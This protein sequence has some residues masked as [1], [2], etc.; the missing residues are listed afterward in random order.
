MDEADENFNSWTYWN[1]DIWDNE[2]NI[3]PD[4]AIVF[5]RPYPMAISGKPEKVKMFNR[6]LK[7]ILAGVY[8]FS[9]CTYKNL[10]MY[11]SFTKHQC[12]ILLR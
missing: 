1:R 7:V 6:L 4:T 12:F 10:Y 11:V 9:F 5:A 8:H 2:G 3:K